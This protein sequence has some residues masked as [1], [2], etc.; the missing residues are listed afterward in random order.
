MSQHP[1]FEERDNSIS[2][3]VNI[4]PNSQKNKILITDYSIEIYIKEPPTKGK[5]NQALIKF[6]SK[7]FE[8]SSSSIKVIRGEKSKK[9]TVSISGLTLQQI[10]ERMNESRG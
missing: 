9:K 4:H 3:S 2:I 7:R 8:I 5:A 1:C 10:L 6:L